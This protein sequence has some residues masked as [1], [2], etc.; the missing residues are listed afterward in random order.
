MPKKSLLPRRP[1]SVF[2]TGTSAEPVASRSYLSSE[3]KAGRLRKLHVGVYTTDVVSEPEDIVRANKW[4]IIGHLLP[5]CT[6]ADR[7][8]AQP[9]KHVDHVFAAWQGPQRIVSLPGLVV[10]CRTAEAHPDDSPW[11]GGLRMSS[12]ARILS[13]N[14]VMS[15]ARSGPARTLTV[16]ELSDWITARRNDW[17]QG[18]YLRIREDALERAAKRGADARLRQILDAVEG[19]GAGGRLVL[20]PLTRANLNGRGWDPAYLGLI[21]RTVERFS[22]WAS[23]RDIPEDLPHGGGHG[24][25]ARVFFEIYFSNFIEGT[26]LDVAIARDVV[27]AGR[28]DDNPD[29]ADIVGTYNAATQSPPVDWTDPDASVRWMKDVHSMVMHGRPYA[30]PGSFKE[31]PN[32]VGTYSFVAPSLTDGTLRRALSLSSEVPEGFARA[33]YVHFA[34]VMVH[35]FADGNGRVARLAMNS[36]ISRCGLSRVIIPTVMRD[37]YIS[38]I[39]RAHNHGDPTSMMA[40]LEE[41]SRWSASVD[42]NVPPSDLE[43]ALHQSNAFMDSTEAWRTGHRLRTSRV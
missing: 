27:E 12:A 13:D 18:R 28:R 32:R 15:R 39:R 24:I 2:F 40:V 42:W 37:E 31:S 41:C 6:I 25:D 8:A 23:K 30:L 43:R 26:E 19:R 4:A 21:S 1:L 5:G 35:P 20:G 11:T 33:A 22:G 16:T 17:G 9:D 14:A 36:E 29:L 3:A 10:K 7:T 38:G 34:I